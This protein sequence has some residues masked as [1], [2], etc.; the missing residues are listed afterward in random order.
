MQTGCQERLRVELYPLAE[1][2]TAFARFTKTGQEER[3]DQLF[4]DELSQFAGRAVAALLEDQ[5]IS[6]T[7]LRDTVLRSDSERSF[8][9]VRGTLHYSLNVGTQLR[10]GQFEHTLVSG[11]GTENQVRLMYPVVL[12]TGYRGKFESWCVEA[13]VQGLVG[14]SQEAKSVS[15]AGGG[16]VDFSGGLGL[17]LHRALL[18]PARPGLLL[19]RGGQHLRAAGVLGHP[20][21]RQAPR[22]RPQHAPRRR[23]GRGRGVRLG[24]HARLQRAV[25]SAGRAGPA[26]L[27]PGHRGRLGVGIHTWY[28]GLALKLGVV[29]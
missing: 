25:L 29:F 12:S 13:Q 23:P 15:N 8:Q 2:W 11:G 20:A 24:V 19:P 9:R 16:H 3:V 7:I 27:R 4:P 18:Q 10:G 1:G 14:T 5:P 6:G 22:G 17:Q 26:G 28:P 21:R